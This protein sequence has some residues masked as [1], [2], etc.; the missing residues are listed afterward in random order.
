M[1]WRLDASLLVD[2]VIFATF[3]RIVEY[4]IMPPSS[5]MF[6]VDTGSFAF[7]R[8]CSAV[9]TKGECIQSRRQKELRW[10]TERTNAVTVQQEIKMK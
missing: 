8:S 7:V 9:S 10:E 6:V 4:K 1:T 2:G 3:A 5:Y